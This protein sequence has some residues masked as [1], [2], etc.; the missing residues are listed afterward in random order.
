M[1]VVADLPAD[2]Q[3]AEPVQVGERTLHE[4]ALGAEAG[5]VLGAATGDQQFHAWIPDETAVFVVAVA[6]VGQ[7][8]VRAASGPAALAS[9]R[10]DSLQKRDSW[11]T[12]LP[13]PPVRV[14]ASEIPVASVIGG[15]Y[16]PS[17]PG[18]RGFVR[19]WSPPFN[20]RI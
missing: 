19:S 11:M 12:S 15:V 1:D 4:P 8:H 18:R 17:C 2:P 5:A 13:L 9:H 20:A 14:T 7:Q 10:R 16:Y 6:A 3:S